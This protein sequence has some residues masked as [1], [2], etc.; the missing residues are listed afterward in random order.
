MDQDYDVS[1]DVEAGKKLKE[2]YKYIAENYSEKYAENLRNSIF[3]KTFG[4]RKNPERYPLE[5]VLSHL[6]GNI[7][8]FLVNSYK[9]IYEIQRLEVTV[10][11]I[12]NT[13]QNPEKLEEQFKF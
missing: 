6:N 2:I 11:Y 10:L 4:L 3:E 1:W 12:F 8:F 7:R 13:R 9:I 5:P